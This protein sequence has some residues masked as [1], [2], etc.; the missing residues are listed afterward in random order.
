MIWSSL[1]FTF[2]TYLLFVCF[3][4]FLFSSQ[5]LASILSWRSWSIISNPYSHGHGVTSY[6]IRL[7]T[8][9]QRKNMVLGKQHRMG[10]ALSAWCTNAF[11]C[12][13][14]HQRVLHVISLSLAHS[15]EPLAAPA[16]KFFLGEGEKEKIWGMH[17]KLTK[18]IFLPFLCWNCQNWFDFYMFVIIW[19]VNAMKYNFAE[20]TPPITPAASPV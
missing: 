4:S 18:L 9:I 11:I 15:T 14:A 19:R 10:E 20:N 3:F 7:C 17:V 12:L 8:T 2:S 6:M 5:T 16:S 13:P 1:T